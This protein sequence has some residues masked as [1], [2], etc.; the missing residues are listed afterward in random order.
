MKIVW[1]EIPRPGK[2]VV[3]AAID[4]EDLDLGI[5]T[6]WD[7][8]VVTPDIAFTTEAPTEPTDEDAVEMDETEVPYIPPVTTSDGPFNLSEL[9]FSVQTYRKLLTDKT[10]W[11]RLLHTTN[12]FFARLTEDELRLFCLFYIEARRTID[13]DLVRG[14]IVSVTT[15]LGNMFYDLAMTIDL[16]PKVLIYVQGN[17]EIPK[18]DFSYAG[19]N[20]GRDRPELTFCENNDLT[21]YYAILAITIICKMLCPLW[22]DMIER[23][24]GDTGNMIKETLCLPIIEPILALDAFRAVSEKI[25]RCISNIVDNEIKN[26]Y[27]NGQFTATV[28]GV[29]RDRF[30]HIINA[31]LIVKKLVTVDLYKEDGNLVIWI[32]TCAKKTYNSLQQ[33]LNRRCQIVPRIDISNTPDWGDDHGVSVLEYGSH[34]TNV[35]ADIPG[36][37][38]F[39]VRNAITRLRKMFQVP[40]NE[41]RM[42][43]TYYNLDMIDVTIFNKVLVGLFV[44]EEIGGAQ[45]LKYLDLTLYM[46][47]VVIVQIYIA[48]TY[49]APSIVHLLTAKTPEEIK[50]V[51][52]LST[53]NMLIGMNTK[54]SPDY[55]ACVRAFPHTIDKVGVSTV[56]AR[57]QDFIVTHHHFY[58]TAP[59]VSANLD[60]PM[61]TVSNGSLLEYEEVVMQQFC[62]ILLERADPTGVRNGE[63]ILRVEQKSS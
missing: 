22:G 42:A 56:L 57:I 2:D 7:E 29:S 45:G 46:E 48:N 24:V 54:H 23:T 15:N 62:M 38:R 32:H 5:P 51:A 61:A 20:I 40:E 9:Y 6:Y 59:I 58:N 33:T 10:M 60:G 30:C 21:E 53:I 27:A 16:I 8:T 17:T 12:Q 47:L 41:F 44:G 18:P 52:K 3:V 39:S 55:Q 36:L 35:T 19:G 13:R 26:T 63:S 28:G 37:L 4:T 49:N 14:S 1:R 11:D 31:Q 50:P 43:M 34:T 25:Y